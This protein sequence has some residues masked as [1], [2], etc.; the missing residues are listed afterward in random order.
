MVRPYLIL[1]VLV[2]QIFFGLSA[3]AQQ[4]PSFAGTWQ[5]TFGDMVLQQDGVNVTGAYVSA[6]LT[7]QITGK[8]EGRTLTFTY[9]EPA[10]AGEGSFD[11]SPD[12]AS[13][14]GRWRVAGTQPWGEWQ[15]QRVDAAG[16]V[17]ATTFS[18]VWNTSFGSMRLTQ[19]ILSR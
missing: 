12:G 7:G 10:A 18:G 15:G 16:A 17:V 3:P 4:P 1:L 5:T 11:L 19:A 8:V 9:K 14:T 13:F 6:G 2:A